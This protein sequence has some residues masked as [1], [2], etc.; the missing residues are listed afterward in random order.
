M[1]IDSLLVSRLY[2]VF[3]KYQ[4]GRAFA[5][6]FCYSEDELAYYATTPLMEIPIDRLVSMLYETGDHWESTKA[7]KH[8]LPRILEVMGPPH[9]VEDMYPEHT[10]ETLLYH[11]FKSWPVAER[12]VVL[13]Y[14]HAIEKEIRFSTDEER[15]EWARGISKISTPPRKRS[16]RP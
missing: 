3:A 8:F 10:F 5:C 13:D 7:Y 16:G 6:D 9:F 4:P 14:L 11:K 2:Q 1:A 12:S 15:K